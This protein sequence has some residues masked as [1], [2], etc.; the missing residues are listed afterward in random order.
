MCRDKWLNITL[1]TPGPRNGHSECMRRAGG[2]C[3]CHF[4]SSDQLQSAVVPDTRQTLGAHVRDTAKL[5]GSSSKGQPGLE[6]EN[7]ACSRLATRG[8]RKLKSWK[9]YSITAHFKHSSLFNG[10]C[11]TADCTTPENH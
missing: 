5:S 11:S 8:I 2:D 7:P 4:S 1:V 3:N 6:N 9:H 10:H